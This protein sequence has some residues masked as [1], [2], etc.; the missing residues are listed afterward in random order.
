VDTLATWSLPYARPL[1]AVLPTYLDDG[2]LAPLELALDQWYYSS[3]AG[4][5]KKKRPLRRRDPGS[6]LVARLMGTMVDVENLRT[7]FRLV[8]S[9]LSP[10]AIR[11]YWLEG[12]THVTQ[13]SFGVL[14][15]A[16]DVEGV[17]SA[18]RGTP[19]AKPLEAGAVTYLQEGALSVLER[20][21]E[22]L[23]TREILVSRREDPLGI[24]V[25]MSFLW[26]KSN[27]ISNIRIAVTGR[28]V[29]LPEDR[30]RRE[31]ILV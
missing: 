14:C 29:G 8:H 10:E 6:K 26:A 27:E 25:V 30:M 21:L 13:A 1:D 18:L 5:L 9:G 24:G 17:L 19:Y 16:E 22:D 3:V 7:A 20:T 23:L 12:G 2:H 4:R 15:S 31:L 11:G 28:S